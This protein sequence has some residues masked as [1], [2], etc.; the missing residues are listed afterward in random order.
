MKKMKNKSTLCISIAKQSGSFG[1]IIHNAGY[2][3]LGLDFFYKA[4]SVNDLQNA[5]RG[6]RSLGIRGC[7]VSMPYK[8][9]VIK[10]IDKLDPIAKKIGA[11]N[12]I[13]ND[14]GTLTGY[15]T[16]V[17]GI[18]KCLKKIRNKKDQVYVIGAGGMAR[19]VLVALTNLKFSNIK[20][21]N[22]TNKKGIKLQNEFSIE[23]IPWL[24]RDKV[25]SDIIINATPIG[26][27]PKICKIPILIHI[28]K[29]INFFI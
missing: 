6:V 10:Y 18:T 19:A 12:T 4:F 21:T 1:T 22:R 29:F 9:E 23:Y 14:N 8:Q 2:Q 13:V 28:I 3:A 25:F 17:V 26:M 20:L 15:N 24:K 5:I 7:S 11:V 16:D 27:Y